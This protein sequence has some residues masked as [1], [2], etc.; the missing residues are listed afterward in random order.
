MKYYF[1]SIVKTANNEAAQILGYDTERG[2]EIKFYDEVSY[3]LKLD[4]II[5][6]HYEVKTSF[7]NVIMSKDIDNTVTKSI[8]NAPEGVTDAGNDTQAGA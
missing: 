1:E 3:G 6:A 8:D 7:G 4:T 5:T 2:A